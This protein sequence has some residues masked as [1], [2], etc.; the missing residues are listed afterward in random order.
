LAVLP[1]GSATAEVAALLGTVRAGAVILTR[2]RATADPTGKVLRTSDG[3]LLFDMADLELGTAAGLD[4][5]LL[6][7]V[8]QAN[9]LEIRY[10]GIDS[11][12]ASRTVGDPGGIH[13]DGFGV[14]APA[15]GER[16]DYGSRLYNFEINLRPRVAEGMPLVVGFRTLQLH[17]QLELWRLDPLPET[18]GI[19]TR[20]NNFLY[21]LQIGAEPYI[22]GAG[23][24]LRLDGTLKAGIYGNHAH[25]GSFSP[26]LGT[27][28]EDTFDRV[29]FVGE[30]G[31]TV[32]YRFSRACEARAGYQLLW[33]YGVALA[34]D[35]SRSTNLLGPSGG[36]DCSATSFYQGAAVSLGFM[37]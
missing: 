21:G 8:S 9:E 36:V 11:W 31:V 28:V 35:Q 1:A 29:A 17:E 18:V 27:T 7:A 15:F 30:L 13:F 14:S 34:P 2:D 33:L 4:I 26:T 25:Q 5:T 23:G 16:I 19:G 6:T 10:F 37:F 32:V 3:A 22:L 24:P 20:A 12:N